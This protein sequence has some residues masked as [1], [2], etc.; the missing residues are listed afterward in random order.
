M[1]SDVSVGVV[2]FV[3][4]GCGSGEWMVNLFN[5]IDRAEESSSSWVF[6]STLWAVGG[7]E[8]G[9]EGLF[10]WLL[11]ILLLLLLLLLLVAGSQKNR[12]A[13]CNYYSAFMIEAIQGLC[14]VLS[15][16]P[17]S[18]NLGIEAKGVKK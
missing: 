7:L 4:T 12:R 15:S 18:S 2:G 10:S 11:S 8:S 3:A 17:F 6:A 14:V 1:F 13:F 16:L 5:C 9:F